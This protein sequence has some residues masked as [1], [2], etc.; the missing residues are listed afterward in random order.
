MSWTDPREC[1]THSQSS[2]NVLPNTSRGVFFLSVLRSE[3]KRSLE[4]KSWAINLCCTGAR[5]PLVRA[6]TPR[7]IPFFKAAALLHASNDAVPVRISG[8][9]LQRTRESVFRGPL[10]SRCSSHNTTIQKL[11]ASTKTKWAAGSFVTLEVRQRGLF[12][13]ISELYTQRRERAYTHY[14]SLPFVCD[15]V[16]GAVFFYTLLYTTCTLYLKRVHPV[17]VCLAVWVYL[18]KSMHL[19][20]V[21]V[22]H[23]SEAAHFCLEEAEM[24]KSKQICFLLLFFPT[25]VNVLQK[26]SLWQCCNYTTVCRK[27]LLEDKVVFLT[28]W[29]A[30]LNISRHNVLLV[31]ICFWCV[32]S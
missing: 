4:N 32:A 28:W 30:G 27:L 19:R 7:C 18:K 31:L 14:G 1:L 3:Q 25:Y 5:Q 22:L 6:H 21:C 13:I 12:I 15:K 29:K 10:S 24:L 26:C 9:C 2:L 8:S 11:A 23:F 16:E 17:Q 20:F